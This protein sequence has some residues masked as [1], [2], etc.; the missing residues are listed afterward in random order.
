M[1]FI[2]I[3]PPQSAQYRNPDTG[4]V[5]Y[6]DG[7]YNSRLRV[8]QQSLHFGALERRT[9]NAVIYVFVVDF[10][11]MFLGILTEHRPL[12]VYG[13]RFALSFILLGKPVIET[14]YVMLLFHTS[15]RCFIGLI[16]RKPFHRPLKVFAAFEVPA[17]II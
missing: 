4:K 9:R 10:K 7:V 5:F 13:Y 8:V 3:F 14:C 6:Y 1:E 11:A 15:P 2:F 12:V 17:D 16:H